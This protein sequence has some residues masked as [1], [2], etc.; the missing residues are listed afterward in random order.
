MRA[1]NAARA[2]EL[3]ETV[4]G[5]GDD[6]LRAT[7][8]LSLISLDRQEGRLEELAQRLESR[9]EAGGGSLPPD[10]LLFELANTLEA[11]GRDDEAREML[12]RLI[13][14]HPG[15]PYGMKAQRR[16]LSATS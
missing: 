6:A 10:A 13:D 9:V 4:A 12:Q 3:W 7:V 14:D 5:S 16:L 2:R 1:G 8:E 11:L 15:S